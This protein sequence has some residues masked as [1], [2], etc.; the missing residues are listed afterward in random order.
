MSSMGR[1][2]RGLG[3]LRSTDFSTTLLVASYNGREGFWPSHRVK[4][5]LGFCPPSSF[6]VARIILLRFWWCSATFQ[7]V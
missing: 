7:W 6:S 1:R 3:S 4:F 5:F 2:L